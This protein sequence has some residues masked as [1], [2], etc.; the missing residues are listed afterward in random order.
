[1]QYFHLESDANNA[2]GSRSLNGNTWSFLHALINRLSSLI[3]TVWNFF[4][5]ELGKKDPYFTITYQ[6]GKHFALNVL[7][8]RLTCD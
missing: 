5:T 3:W 7:D 1:M 6:I 2:M 8:L 4:I